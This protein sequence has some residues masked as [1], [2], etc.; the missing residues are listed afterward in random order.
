MERRN[1]GRTLRKAENKS[2]EFVIP[3]KH[4]ERQWSIAKY[5][6]RTQELPVL[7][8]PQIK[9]FSERESSASG[10]WKT[11]GG[12]ATAEGWSWRTVAACKEGIPLIL[13]CSCILRMGVSPLSVNV[14]F[15]KAV[16]S[17]RPPWERPGELVVIFSYLTGWLR[18]RL[19]LLS[20]WL[21]RKGRKSGYFL[22][23]YK[24]ARWS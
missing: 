4:C 19:P 21:P 20:S 9:P 15:V 5:F 24:P 17:S 6:S 1:N 8:S 18:A 7:I 23:R 13:C 10:I 2:N 16:V 3:Q 22:P 12:S 11:F 14:Q